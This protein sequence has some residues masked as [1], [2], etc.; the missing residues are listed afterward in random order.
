MDAWDGKYMGYK[1]VNVSKDEYLVSHGMRYFT[2]RETL[3]EAG[4][5]MGLE[6]VL[7]D[8]E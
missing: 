6:K 3:R 1:L 8:E 5:V 2:Q 4:F 7:E